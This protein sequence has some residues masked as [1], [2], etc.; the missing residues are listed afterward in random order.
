MN[1]RMLFCVCVLASILPLHAADIASLTASMKAAYQSGFFP[2][3]VRYADDILRQSPHSESGALASS[4]KGECLYRMGRLTEAKNC[5]QGI[6]ASSDAEIASQSAY[7][8]GRVF[9]DMQQWND[10]LGCYLKSATAAKSLSETNSY[11][12]YSLYFAAGVYYALS[13]YENAAR[14]YA[15]VVAHG[16]LYVLSDYEK[17]ALN[18]ASSYNALSRYADCILLCSSLKDAAFSKEV[19]YRLLLHYGDALSGNKDYKGAYKLYCQ[20]LAE[21]PSSSLAA[22]AM[23]KAYETS[24]VHKAAVGEEP[25]AVL[26]QAQERLSDYPDLLG[27]FWLRLAIDAYTSGDAEKARSYFTEAEKGASA[28]QLQTAAL[29]RA[30]MAFSAG[31]SREAGAKDALLLLEQCAKET[32][33]VPQSPLFASFTTAQARYAGLSGAWKS[34][35]QYADAVLSLR[36]GVEQNTAAYWK[37]VALYAAGSYMETCAFVEARAG[38]GNVSAAKALSG[39]ASSSLDE[40]LLHLYARSL[41]K[42]GR[43]EDADR[44][45]SVL[46]AKADRTGDTALD[47]AKSQLK[48][49]FLT[50]ASEQAAFAPGA[51]ADYIAAL[52]AFNRR[53]WKDAVTLF[54]KC[55]Q[56]KDLQSPYT[57]YARFYCGY[58]QY[59][60]GSFRA[61]F[62]TL[63]AFSAA[64]PMPNLHFVALVTAVRASVQLGAYEQAFPLAEKAVKTAMNGEQKQE[65]VLLCASVYADSAQYQKALSVLAPYTAQRDDFGYK[66][67]YKTAQI[68]MQMK[69]FAAAEKTYSAFSKERGA[70]SLAEEAAYRRGELV[71]ATG[72]YTEAVPLF[73][74]YCQHWQSGQFVDAALFFA[75][76]ALYKSG[77]SSRAILYYEQVDELKQNSPYKYGAEKNLVE[78]YKE[79]KEYEKAIS[80]A[81]KLLSVYGEQ[82]KKDG[83]EQAIEE[84]KLLELGYD[85]PT[86]AKERSY[87]ALGAT[88]T[89]SGRAAGTELAAMW[90]SSIISKQRGIVLAERLLAIQKQNLPQESAAATKNALLVAKHLREQTENVRSAEL[91]L[92]AAEYARMSGSD[93]SAVQALYGAVEAF[94]AAGLFGDSRQTAL[95]MAQLYPKS[96]YTHAAE[97]LINKQV[98]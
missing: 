65:A 97:Q 23:Q 67:C 56:S 12:A 30:E 6:E 26:S 89:E 39:V 33:L 37:A 53:Q 46:A 13:D 19:L 14:L 95:S 10:A 58:A 93:D 78:L 88:R 8:L 70:G 63:T 28:Q 20:V 2:G 49:G 1:K 64:A 94:D 57:S 83:I 50:S 43:A 98:D 61:A 68:Q 60:A 4:Y 87:N 27:E 59:R 31:V 85:E 44:I 54:E 48:G 75:G 71:Y 84:L 42:L 47:Y 5:L 24:S 16:S 25:G 34:C 79:Q 81:K 55:L 29:Y 41:S 91:Y 51:E 15:F 90:A 11:Y 92:S 7:W 9:S 73:D 32:K 74:F 72:R 40:T 82:A 35:A 38:V 62:D 45:F 80:Y 52:S 76:G 21:S 17:A 3:V 66:C 22:F 77:A 69:D 86:A 96:Y 18:L 36:A